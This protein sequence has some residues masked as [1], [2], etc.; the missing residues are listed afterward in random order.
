[1]REIIDKIKPIKL[2][3]CPIEDCQC[4]MGEYELFLLSG[5]NDDLI[6]EYK[7]VVENDPNRD[8]INMLKNNLG[9]NNQE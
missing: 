2:P 1:M 6:G 3:E 5:C 8:I 9:K 4:N 7:P